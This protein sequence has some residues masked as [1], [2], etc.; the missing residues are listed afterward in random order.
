MHIRLQ[1]EQETVETMIHMYCKSNHYA[2]ETP[3]DQCSKLIHYAKE[4]VEHCQFGENKT[5]CGK[6]K[7]H[8]YTP[9]MRQKI[10]TVM[11]TTGYKML[12]R[13][14]IM[15]LKHVVDMVRH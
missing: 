14:P 2:K 6:C 12:Y 11:R 13:H 3:C 7:V 10:K 15:L 4:R 9:Q 1:R 8:C 5:I